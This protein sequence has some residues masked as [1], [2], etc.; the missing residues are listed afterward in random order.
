MSQVHKHHRKRRSQGGDDGYG[1]CID[2]TPLEHEM[3]HRNVE[4]AYQHGL[5]V[6]SHDDPAQIRPDLAGFRAALGTEIV[7]PPKRKRLQGDER[8]KRKRVSIA[9]PEGCDGGY[10]DELLADAEQVEQSQPDTQYEQW[11]GSISPGKLLV[12]VLERFTGRA[13]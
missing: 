5:L 1:N 4:L 9:L 2:L 7:E 3:V 12:A 11:R 13:G 10:W 8:A 6:K